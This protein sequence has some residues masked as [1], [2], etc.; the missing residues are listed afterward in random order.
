MEVSMAVM[1]ARAVVPPAAGEGL[2]LVPMDYPH[3]RVAHALFEHA[4]GP[5]QAPTVAELEREIEGDRVWV[6]TE[7][8]QPIGLVV[9]EEA[10]TERYALVDLVAP[11]VGDEALVWALQT[12]GRRL[13]REGKTPAAVVDAHDAR[14]IAVFRRSGYFTAATYLIFYDPGAGRPQVPS[15]SREDLLE[16][17]ESGEP[18]RLVDVLGEDHW[19][20]GHL[21][22][23]VWVDYRNL[24]REARE[25]FEP[26]EPIV[27][28]CNDYT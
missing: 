4:R 22:G 27:V 15:I 13:E 2:G 8:D 26:G 5:E 28:Y 7:K 19:L 6:L 16:M 25:R 17:V 1:A 20:R 3:L 14:K 10:R 18:F 24:V 23:A 12:M 21:P 11:H 9:E